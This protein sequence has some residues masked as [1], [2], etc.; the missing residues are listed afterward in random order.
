M[1]F[2]Q[3]VISST[4]ASVLNIK[5]ITISGSDKVLPG[6]NYWCYL[7]MIYNRNNAGNVTS[8]RSQS[9]LM[10]TLERRSMS[11]LLCFQNLER[12]WRIS[13]NFLCMCT[14]LWGSFLYNVTVVTCNF[15]VFSFV[16]NENFLLDLITE[17]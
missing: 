17:F 12:I 13:K 15:P 9:I 8:A 4:T 14:V 7:T 3:Y 10:T 6:R 16:F 5:Q 2:H 11:F 1:L